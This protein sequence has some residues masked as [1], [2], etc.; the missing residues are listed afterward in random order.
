[1]SLLQ[2]IILALVQAFTEFLPVSSTAHLILFPWLLH[3]PDPGLAFDVAL[4]AGTLLA[5]I[6][7]FFKD[8]IKLIACGLGMQY[9]ANASAEEISVNKRMFWYMVIGT[10]PAAVLGKLFHHQIEDELRK[11]II[12]GVS[13]LVIALVMWWADSKSRLNRKLESSNMGDALAIGSAQAIAL[14]PG[15][16]RSGITITA[17]L[18]RGFTREAAT[19]FS[20][21]LSTPVIAGAVLTEL[22]KLIHMHKAGGLDLPMS[23]LVVSILVSGV[24]GYF[25]I[26]FFL[27]YL[28]TKTLKPFIIYRLLL[29]LAVLAT[30]FFQ[31]GGR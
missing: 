28:Q 21:L 18:F 23:T 25:V 29:G 9:P 7:Y 17:G 26:A 11:P 16:S 31:A 22:P 15:V 24:A 20:F 5:V 1:M 13:L 12:I 19:R 10:I 14:W 2:A 6:L 3:W 30:A 4:H 27:K 8:W